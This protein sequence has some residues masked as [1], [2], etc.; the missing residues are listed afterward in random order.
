MHTEATDGQHSMEEMVAAAHKLGYE[1]I[2]ITD[3]SPAVGIV[4]GLKED[5]FFDH[6]KKI[7]ALDKKWKGKLRILKGAEVDIHED[8]SLDYPDDMLKLLDLVNISVHSKFSLPPKEQ[9]ARVLKAISNPYVTMLCHPTGR[10]VKQ[11]EPFSID[12]VEVARTAATHR[13]ALEVNG[14]TRLD[15]SSGN[16]RLTHPYGV[17]YMVNTDAHQVAQLE[18]MRFGVQMARRGWLEKKDILNTLP[19]DK[20]MSYFRPRKHPVK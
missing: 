12:L 13:V 9:T 17:K 18:C 5:R 3:H 1:Y 15:L 4:N 2:A 6:L 11:R 19:L 8:G 10:I 16:I 14:S 20:M 7:D